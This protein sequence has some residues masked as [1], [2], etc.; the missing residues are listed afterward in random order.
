MKHLARALLLLP[1]CAMAALAADPLLGTWKVI[2]ESANYPAGGPPA[3]VVLRYEATGV[4]G[5]VKFTLNGE[6]RGKPYTYSWTAKADGKRYKPEGQTSAQEVEFQRPEPNHA[7]AI[8]YREGQEI[9]RH[10]ATVSADG[11]VMTTRS[12]SR[13]RDGSTRDSEAQYRKQ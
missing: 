12:H 3:N 2:P 13:N 11:Q 7:I 4:E 1:V 6:M 5:E 8:H 10:D 9:A